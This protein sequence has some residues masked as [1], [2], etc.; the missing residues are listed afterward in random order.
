MEKAGERGR[1]DNIT[2]KHGY[3]EWR[4]HVNEMLYVAGK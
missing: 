4:N 3:E 2:H 1:R